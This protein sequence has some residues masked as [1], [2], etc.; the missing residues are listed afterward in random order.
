MSNESVVSEDSVIAS[1]SDSCDE[2][3][4]FDETESEYDSNLEDALDNQGLYSL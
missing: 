1:D 4:T 3:Y 2:S